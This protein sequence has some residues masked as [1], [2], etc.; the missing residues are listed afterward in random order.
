MEALIGFGSGGFGRHNSPS[1]EGFDSDHSSRDRNYNM[2]IDIP[3]RGSSTRNRNNN[4]A[5]IFDRVDFDDLP[6]R[7]P[8]PLLLLWIAH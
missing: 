4:N 2:V 3:A 6:D 5:H 8:A 7:R 1:F